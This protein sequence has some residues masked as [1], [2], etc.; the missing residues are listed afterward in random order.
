MNSFSRSHARARVLVAIA[1]VGVAGSQLAGAPAAG[2][3]QL[4]FAGLRGYLAQAFT[5][6]SPRHACTWGLSHC[7]LESEVGAY[8]MQR[9]CRSAAPRPWPCDSA[10]TAAGSRSLVSGYYVCIVIVRSRRSP[11]YA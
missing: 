9:Q 1:G 11:T 3:A 2:A 4:I 7:R 8:N 5:H 10:V 6:W